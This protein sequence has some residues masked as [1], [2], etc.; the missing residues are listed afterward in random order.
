MVKWWIFE[1][2]CDLWNHFRR[3]KAPNRQKNVTRTPSY[4]RLVFLWRFFAGL[5]LWAVK[6]GS[7][8]QVLHKNG[9]LCNVLCACSC[10]GSLQGRL[11]TFGPPRGHAFRR[12][13]FC[14]SRGVRLSGVW[15][16][17]TPTV[18][19]KQLWVWG[20]RLL[21]V[22]PTVSTLGFRILQVCIL[23]YD[24]SMISKK[25]LLERSTVRNEV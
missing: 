19:Q 13:R 11:S 21:I 25:N 22:E 6:N 24:I 7:T 12:H 1:K 14:H 4:S 20:I 18:G 10:N 16:Q 2:A 3:P 9:H 5:G 15:T 17:T 8:S 23:S